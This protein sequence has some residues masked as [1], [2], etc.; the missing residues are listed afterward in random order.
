[1]Y[2]RDLTVIPSRD[3][4]SLRHRGLLLK[5]YSE[6]EGKETDDDDRRYIEFFEDFIGQNRERLEVLEKELLEYNY[7]CG[8]KKQDGELV[9]IC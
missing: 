8:Y 1:M 9:K 5:R 6:T 4:K 2:K 3:I 7:Q